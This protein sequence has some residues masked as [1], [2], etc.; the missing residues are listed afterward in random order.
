MKTVFRTLFLP[1]AALVLLLVPA[2][3]HALFDDIDSLQQLF[4]ESVRPTG[5]DL[6][7]E[8]M[9]K[10]SPISSFSDVDSKSW[11][12]PFVS[13]MVRRGIVSGDLDAQGKPKGTFRPQDNVTMAEALKIVFRAARIDEKAC[14]QRPRNITAVTHWASQFVACAEGLAVRCLTE[15]TFIDRP[16][17]R[18]EVLSLIDDVF[19]EAVPGALP[20]FRDAATHRFATDIAYNASIG[21]ISGDTDSNG[22]PTGTFRPNDSLR[23]A[24][25]VKIVAKKIEILGW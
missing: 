23:R 14:T 13:T 15:F 25:M 1:L 21:I 9:N 3:T 16:I 7:V 12:A 8:E 5:L 6:L 2:P 18:A 17:S 4:R 22:R 11:Y 24:E 10:R 19:G 20:T